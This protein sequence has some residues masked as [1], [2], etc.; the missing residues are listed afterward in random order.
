MII[1][2]NVDE[3]SDEIDC[4]ASKNS[5]TINDDVNKD[6]DEIRSKEKSTKIVFRFFFLF[7]NDN[8]F[9][10]KRTTKIVLRFF[11][12]SFRR[13]TKD[14]IFVKR[15]TDDSDENNVVSYELKRN[16]NWIRD[17]FYFSFVTLIQSLLIDS[18]LVR[19]LFDEIH[20]SILY[21]QT[22]DTTNV[23]QIQISQSTASHASQ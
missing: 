3:N 13:A 6:D 10:N 8:T 9:E 23:V 17:E 21:C 5:E 14:N 16:V 4:D 22:H 7:T 18:L 15:T 19:H 11:F 20:Q 12:F 1:S 2:F